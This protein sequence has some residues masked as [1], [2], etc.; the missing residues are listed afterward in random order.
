MHCENK[1]EGWCASAGEKFSEQKS[2]E[3]ENEKE[4]ARSI[5]T[6]YYVPHDTT[7]HAQQG[8]L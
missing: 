1:V 4:R 6:S 8:A 5:V 3:R 7:A 2:V